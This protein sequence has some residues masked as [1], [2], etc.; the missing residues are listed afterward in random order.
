MSMASRDQF[1]YSHQLPEERESEEV[2]R[3]ALPCVSRIVRACA[4]A[5]W[6]TSAG[7]QEAE[8]E[9]QGIGDE[10]S[11]K[12][13]ARARDRERNEENGFISLVQRINED[14]VFFKS[15]R[16]RTHARTHRTHRTHRTRSNH[17]LQH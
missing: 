14:G 4:R 7:R 17:G 13:L 10:R 2:A 15:Y 1:I 5:A 6:L 12:L 3:S 16:Y 8:A 9:A 11:K